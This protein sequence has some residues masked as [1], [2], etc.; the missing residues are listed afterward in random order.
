MTKISERIER[1]EK[2]INAACERAGRDPNTVKLI[3]VTKSADIKAVKEVISLGYTDLA[4][5]RVQQ[6]KKV[7]D[8]ID[9]YLHNDRDDSV[10][11]PTI[12][13]HFSHTFGG[14]TTPRRRNK[15]LCRKAKPVS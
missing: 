15:Y 4:E 9:A 5:N 1:V 10:L 2:T 13:W 3:I 11:S 8:V 7:Y 14:H 6:L 12:N